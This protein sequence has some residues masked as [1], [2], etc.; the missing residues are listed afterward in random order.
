MA[1]R[2]LEVGKKYK[3]INGTIITVT[4]LGSSGKVV[5][6]SDTYWRTYSGDL[7][8]AYCGEEFHPKYGRHI[9]WSWSE[10]KREQVQLQLL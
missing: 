6:C 10:V 4:S 8:G 1:D 2:I 5:M 9:D 3:L 7:A